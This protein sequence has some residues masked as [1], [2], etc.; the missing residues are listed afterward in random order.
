MVRQHRTIAPGRGA[1]TGAHSPKPGLA[2]AVSGGTLFLDEVGDILPPM[3]VRLLRLL[4]SGT[5]RRVVS[6]EPRRADVRV[7]S[8]TH[9]KLKTM[10][11]IT[12]G[13]SERTLYRSLRDIEG[14]PP[15]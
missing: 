9:W 6:T 8:A 2:E 15:L 12:L 1:F 14:E 7:I 11:A 13:I 10:L 5:C 3:Q 4:E